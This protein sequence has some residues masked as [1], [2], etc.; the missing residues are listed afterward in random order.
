MNR[1][2]KWNRKTS[3]SRISFS[4]FEQKE[5]TADMK[6]VD[7]SGK[8]VTS[9]ENKEAGELEQ[10]LSRK[11]EKLL[12]PTLNMIKLSGAQIPQQQ[13]IQ[14]SSMAHQMLFYRM[15]YNLA[16]KVGIKD[17]NELVSDDDL[18]ELQTSLKNQLQVVD[19]SS[20]TSGKGE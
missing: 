20:E 6:I 10:E 9:K 19:P 14:L 1:L 15:V 7:P 5:K 8:E 3:T 2:L 16:V 11:A 4:K 17:L 18:E 12:E 13:L